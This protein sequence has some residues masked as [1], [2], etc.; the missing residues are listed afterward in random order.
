MKPPRIVQ[1][2]IIRIAWAIAPVLSGSA[3]ASALRGW[4]PA[5]RS[6]ASAGLWGLWAVT[7][8]ASLVAHPVAMTLVRVLM[9]A[10]FAVTMAAALAGQPPSPV[11]GLAA[12]MAFSPDV[13]YWFV[14]GP[15]YPNESRFPLRAPG[16][17]VA[18]LLPLFWA[19]VV[20]A[21]AATALL[22]AER[23]WGAAVVVGL[24]GL[25]LASLVTRSLHSLSRRWLVFVPAGVVLHDPLTLA[26]PVLF[27]SKQIESL[28]AAP[29]DTDSLDLTLG[30]LG[31][32]L[33]L[34]LTDKVPM[35]RRVGRGGV[36][37][38]SSA[39]VLVAPSRP[40]AVLAESESRR[41]PRA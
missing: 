34:I 1:V 28:D 26:D 7:L 17:L 30:S 24:I 21:P 37:A 27:P 16:Y 40:L 41:L 19:L 39:R 22:L 5:P 11:T 14:N 6:V 35:V 13:G 3:F 29:V 15:A 20:A 2:W 12:V 18:G 25:P 31:T 8:L 9:P 32:A 23:K 33:E 38:G 36:E 10:G 4:D